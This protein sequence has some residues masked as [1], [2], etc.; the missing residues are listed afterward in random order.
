M[1]HRPIVKSFLFLFSVNI[2]VPATT[3]A[4]S[5]NIFTDVDSSTQYTRAIQNLKESNIISGYDDGTFAPES[6]INRAE[7]TKILVNSVAKSNIKG[8]NCFPDVKDDWYAPYVCTAKSLKLIDGYPDGTF[9]PAE[10]INFAEASKIIAN[11][12][13]LN[14]N[15]INIDPWFKGFV[16][17]LS[18]KNA[19]PLSVEY[20][21]QEIN[22][23]EMSEMIWRIS[24]N[25]NNKASRTFQEIQGDGI[26]TIKSCAD[27]EERMRTLK[28][29]KGDG[30]YDEDYVTD[31]ARDLELP[32]SSGNL[33]TSSPNIKQNAAPDF[34]QT[35]TQVEGVDEGDIIKNDGK[36][37][38]ILKDRSLRII[39]AYP[40]EKMRELVNFKL[41][42]TEGGFY[43][44]DMYV[45]GDYLVVIGS[46]NLRSPEIFDQGNTYIY[47]YQ[48]SHSLVYV[49]DIKDRANP[50]ILRTLGMDGDY[51]NSRRVGDFV[52]LVLNDYPMFPYV[53]I[54]TPIPKFEDYLPHYSDSSTNISD[55]LI[56]P[57][58]DYQYIPK[59][60]NFNLLIT[61]A[62]PIKD[63]N[64][65][66]SREVLIGSGEEI[67]AS[68]KNLY[69]T[70]S[71]WTG[72]YRYS[73]ISQTKIYKYS[74][75][76]EKIKFVAEGA[77][78]GDVL[79]QFSM[80]EYQGNFRIATTESSYD[81]FETYHSNNLFILDQNLKQIGKLNNIAKG[82]EI[83]SVRFM[84]E[85][86][87]IVTFKYIDPFMVFDLSNPRNPKLLG[88]LK[89]P[90]YSDYLHPY[91]Q[92]HIIGF[93]KDVDPAEVEKDQDFIYYTAVQGFKM[94][95]FDVT[96]PSHPKEI[97]KEII[98]DSGTYS[99][100]LDNH[101]A[102]LFDK[103]KNL[104]A[105]PISV[106][107]LPKQEA[108]CSDFTYS[109]CPSSCRK[110]CV[111]KCEVQNGVRICDNTCDGANSCQ[112]VQSKS[113]KAVFEGAYVYGVD[114]N[115][116]FTLRG[117]I[118]HLDLNE[119][120]EL[121]AY[122]Y[123]TAYNKVIDRIIY[124]GNSLYTISQEVVKANDLNNN[125]KEISKIQLKD[126]FTKS[127]LSQFIENLFN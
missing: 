76:Q 9:K 25:I 105:F 106:Y 87:Y 112:Q 8:S 122:G 1:K 73:G 41:E 61:V 103:E 57:C 20:F 116:G 21:D 92:N 28:L 35:N 68:D 11:A 22:R 125:L 2:L 24:N 23:G 71:D 17:S 12:Y 55:Q 10:N 40:A 121:L 93:G 50:K 59:F 117:K 33:M 51:Q 101:K 85:R 52:Y 63:F 110:V 98:G 72:A 127:A 74:L 95:L 80:D 7:F 113:P 31:F 5:N 69:I 84:G 53:D 49:I 119:Q 58:G 115:K 66:V 29:N 79:N 13:Q 67:Y 123:N 108:A 86:A 104:I 54:N 78:P 47:P 96:D 60:K 89:I 126:Q 36:Y 30:F 109:S 88:E 6:E 3:V 27:L 83:Y 43:P 120:N 26:S 65:Q 46:E 32:T 91:D 14:S 38:Y 118:S 4:Q 44:I 102:L 16:D 75:D 70:S 42:G 97:A 64:K 48:K 39:N 77:V 56:L 62:I 18:N 107:E 99:E 45:D 15:Q 94:G 100:L 90:G 37:I 82:E 81:R 111:P 114:L 34:S 124:I 19:I